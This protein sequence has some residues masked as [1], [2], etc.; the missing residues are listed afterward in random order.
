MVQGQAFRRMSDG[1]VLAGEVVPNVNIFP[2]K[3]NRAELAGTNIIFQTHDRRQL[4][5]VGN[6]PGKYLV[7]F[8]DLNFALEPKYQGLLPRHDFHWFKAGVQK[9]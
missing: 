8:N 9:K 2:A 7:I 4:E 1:T 5:A 6:R 3:P